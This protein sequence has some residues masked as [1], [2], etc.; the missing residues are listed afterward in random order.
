ME[1][2]KLFTTVAHHPE[3]LKVMRGTGNLIY[4]SGLLDANL[5]ELII[6][7][8]CARKG[9]EYEWGVHAAL[10]GKKHNLAG[11]RLK[12]VTFDDTLGEGFSEQE[13]AVVRAVDDLCE[14]AEVGDAAWNDLRANGF[15]DAQILEV[16]A[17]AG[18]YHMI[19]FIVRTTRVEKEDFGLTFEA[20]R[21]Q[22]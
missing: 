17:I 12:A 15:S 9:A 13:R 10:F 22:S 16:V 2:L 4:K 8:V 19:V 11:A 14:R 21:K 6:Q 3:V 5:R 1:P 18:L 7:R 20:L